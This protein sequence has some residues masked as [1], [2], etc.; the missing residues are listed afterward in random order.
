MCEQFVVGGLWVWVFVFFFFL[1]YLNFLSVLIAY[2][3]RRCLFSLI[4]S[5]AGWIELTVIVNVSLHCLKLSFGTAFS[6]DAQSAQKWVK[7]SSVSDGFIS[8]STSHHGGKIPRKLAN[9][10]VDRVWQE[11]NMNRTQN[12]YVL[13]LCDTEGN[14]V[15]CALW[16]VALVNTLWLLV[17]GVFLLVKTNFKGVNWFLTSGLLIS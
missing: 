12:K 10:V 14:M 4:F 2:N 13:S 15:F 9:Q 11:C 1:L 8:D 16:K 17:E 5:R 3:W 7:F 6:V